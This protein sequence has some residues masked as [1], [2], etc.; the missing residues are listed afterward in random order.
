[1]ELVIHTDEFEARAKAGSN[2]ELS[3]VGSTDRDSALELAAFVRDLHVELLAHGAQRV[4]VDIR[5]L[6]FLN[7]TCFNVFVQWLSTIKELAEDKRY[8]L[9]FA[10]DPTVHWQQRTVQTLFAFAP[11][12]VQ[13]AR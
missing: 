9:Q 4:V 5:R 7:A 12:L 8:Q 11:D 13:A 10:T 1:M 2:G 3:L 6:E